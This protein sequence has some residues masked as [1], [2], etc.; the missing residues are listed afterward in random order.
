MKKKGFVGDPNNGEQ[1]L[2]FF[3]KIFLTAPLPERDVAAMNWWVYER[4]I[5]DEC[6]PGFCEE[7]SQISSH[8]D[9]P[10]ARS[11]AFWEV[12]L[13]LKMAH[14]KERLDLLGNIQ[15]LPKVPIEIVHG[16]EDYLCPVKYAEMLENSLKE[17]GYQVNANYVGGG[18][19]IVGPL[20]KAGVRDAVER[21]A[22]IYGK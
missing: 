2:S 3:M 14:G 12:S 7:F 15:K 18:H 10:E 22:A 20:V 13:I 21:F 17:H 9:L 1:L 19:K 11:V 8:K 16:K 6:E 5:M 4:F